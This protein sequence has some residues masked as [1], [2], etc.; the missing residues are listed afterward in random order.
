MEN[1]GKLK[2]F[3]ILKRIRSSRPFFN[4][5]YFKFIQKEKSLLFRILSFLISPFSLIYLGIVEIKRIVSKKFKLSCHVISVGN[6]TMG[7]TGKT[8][9]VKFLAERFLSLG[10][11]VAIITSGIGGDRSF[12]YGK[13]EDL[14]KNKDVGDEVLLLS[15][16]L[17]HVYI[18]K[19]KNKLKLV[20]FAE[21]EISP[22][23]I[24][25][26]DGFH[27]YGIEKSLDIVVIDGTRKPGKLVLPSG[28]LREPFKNLKR[29]D[30][31]ILNHANLM[32]N[33]DIEKRLEKFKKKIFYMWY[34]IGEIK[35][36]NGKRISP[37]EIKGKR[38]VA[39]AGIGNPFSFFS[40]ILKLKPEIVYGIPFPDHFKYKYRDY[41]EIK[42]IFFTTSSHFILTTEKDIYKLENFQDIENLYFVKIEPVID[43]RMWEEISKIGL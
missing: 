27:C 10:K 20:H 36:L 22:D 2:S 39:F 26:D 40:L 11:K 31:F 33:N 34:R 19:G 9:V 12:I 32:E 42:K 28:I 18:V 29:A 43:E 37:S 24:I 8:T 14:R 17:P 6:I 3:L 5:F 16:N 30:F 41:K 25:I 15:N 35:N 4:F 38:V 7:G 21:K 23:I 13:G 1:L